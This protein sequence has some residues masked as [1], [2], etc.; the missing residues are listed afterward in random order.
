[1]SINLISYINLYY[2]LITVKASHY[3]VNFNL[4]KDTKIFLYE[5][6][7]SVFVKS[8]LK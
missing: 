5:Q 6:I 4:K 7:N 2:L 3:F 8:I 1:M